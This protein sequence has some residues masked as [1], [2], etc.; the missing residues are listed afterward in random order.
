MQD[1]IEK[2]SGM[3]EDDMEEMD[4]A[5]IQQIQLFNV[6]LKQED[7]EPVTESEISF[8]GEPNEYNAYTTNP[9]F[10]KNIYRTLTESG[11]PTWPD[12]L[13]IKISSSSE[14]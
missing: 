5:L 13:G 6:A 14:I 4:E 12:N 9:C 7:G 3:E 11:P 2:L 1:V 8:L 10:L